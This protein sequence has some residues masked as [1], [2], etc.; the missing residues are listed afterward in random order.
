MDKDKLIAELKEQNKLLRREGQAAEKMDSA[1]QR[2]LSDHKEQ[3]YNKYLLARDA[4]FAAV[5]A[6]MET[7]PPF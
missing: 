6:R 5:A 1:L 7:E 3:S 4:W 2:W